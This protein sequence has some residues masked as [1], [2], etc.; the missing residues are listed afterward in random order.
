MAIPFV[1]VHPQTIAGTLAVRSVPEAGTQAV[2][3]ILV[4]CIRSSSYF[5]EAFQRQTKSGSCLKRS[6]TKAQVSLLFP[7]NYG[8]TTLEIR[9]ETGAVPARGDAPGYQRQRRE[10]AGVGQ[11]FG[12]AGSLGGGRVISGPG[13]VEHC[14]RLLAVLLCYLAIVRFEI[15]RE[16]FGYLSR[17]GRRFAPHTRIPTYRCWSPVH[18]SGVAEGQDRSYLP[19]SRSFE[20]YR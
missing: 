4:F 19:S 20:A 12:A 17:P 13:G 18:S 3:V 9:P 10:Q 15:A 1:D 2:V 7:M 8:Y 14:L 5:S 11:A 6:G 16:Q